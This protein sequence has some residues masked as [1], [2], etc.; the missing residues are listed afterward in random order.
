MTEANKTALTNANRAIAAG[1]IEGF[2][3]HC[4]EDILWHAVGQSPIHGKAALREWMRTAY[5][6]RPT[7]SVEQLVTENDWVVALGTIQ[8][9]GDD[10]R[11]NGHLYS[12][13]WRFREGRMAELRAFVIKPAA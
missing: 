8:V 5:A 3:L 6:E 1:D 12:D 9:R 11:T 10:G 4:T 7:F 13:A 2:L